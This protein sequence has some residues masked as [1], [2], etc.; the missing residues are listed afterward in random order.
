MPGFPVGRHAAG[1]GAPA[2]P[3]VAAALAQRPPGGAR[4]HSDENGHEPGGSERGGLGWPGPP[5]GDGGVGW[6]PDGAAE[7][8]ATTQEPAVQRWGWRRLFG[9]RAA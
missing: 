7:N 2:H 5:P 4:R 1:Q 3:L 9:I 6:P 8:V